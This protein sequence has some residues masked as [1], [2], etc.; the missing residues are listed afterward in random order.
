MG[1]R[2]G[3]DAV[4]NRKTLFPAGM[5]LFIIQKNVILATAFEKKDT[6]LKISPT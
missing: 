4:E 6:S 5:W 1:L 3:L 2:A